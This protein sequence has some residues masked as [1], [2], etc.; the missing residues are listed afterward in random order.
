MAEQVLSIK[1]PITMATAGKIYRD[2]A[3]LSAQSPL[4]ID[5]SGMEQAI[6]VPSPS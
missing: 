3:T 2:I 4:Y 1:G 5:F 6:P